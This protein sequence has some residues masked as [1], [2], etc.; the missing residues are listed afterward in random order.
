MLFKGFYLFDVLEER[1]VVALV[2]ILHLIPSLHLHHLEG[3]ASI[4]LVRRDKVSNIT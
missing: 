1:D 3:A 4:K 2:H